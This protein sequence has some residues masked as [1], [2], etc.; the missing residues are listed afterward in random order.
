MYGRQAADLQRDLATRNPDKF[1]PD[2]AHSLRNLIHNLGKIGQHQDVVDFDREATGLF[3]KV[4]RT[5]PEESQSLVSY[6]RLL[7]PSL[8]ILG[9]YG[10]AR[11]AALEADMVER[12]L[13]STPE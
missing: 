8:D 4:V 7:T 1:N 9:L 12:E 10:E 11:R 13:N 3:R 5:Q 6:L 2:L